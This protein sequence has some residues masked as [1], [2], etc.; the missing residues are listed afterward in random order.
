MNGMDYCSKIGLDLKHAR[1]WPIRQPMST[2]NS[3]NEW[4]TK[5]VHKG[6][7]TNS[8][9]VYRIETDEGNS[10]HSK[11]GIRSQTDEYGTN[12]KDNVSW[13]NF[14]KVNASYRCRLNFIYFHFN[15]IL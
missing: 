4:K 12:Y 13:V 1:H 11:G 5:K 7:A 15:L 9:K 14:Y 8:G 10:E 2:N 6:V 3:V